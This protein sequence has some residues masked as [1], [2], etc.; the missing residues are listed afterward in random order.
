MP[1][2]GLT[3]AVTAVSANAENL[4]AKEYATVLPVRRQEREAGPELGAGP[5]GSRSIQGPAVAPA[6]AVFTCFGLTFCARDSRLCPPCAPWPRTSL[7]DIQGSC[8]LPRNVRST[9]NLSCRE[10][11]GPAAERKIDRL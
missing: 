3:G 5:G 7:V 9:C 1:V 2:C 8:F 6:P 10:N 11:A 4:A